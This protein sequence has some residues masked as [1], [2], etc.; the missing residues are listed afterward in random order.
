MK[1]SVCV[2]NFHSFR[3]EQVNVI[4]FILIILSCVYLL[5]IIDDCHVFMCIYQLHVQAGPTLT[6]VIDNCVP[7]IINMLH[8]ILHFLNETLHY[9]SN[10]THSLDKYTF[11]S[12][13]LI[14]LCKINS[15]LKNIYI[16]FL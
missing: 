2:T 9:L 10:C 16:F 3:H 15:S 14:F 7:F 11:K 1:L 8:H 12:K 6:G 13:I 4:K 5:V